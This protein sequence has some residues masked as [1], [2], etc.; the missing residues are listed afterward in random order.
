MLSRGRSF[1]TP[2]YLFACLVMGG[3]A[4][5]IWANM[6]LQL[7][8]LAIIA[9]AAMDRSD[10]RLAPA[11]WQLLALAAIALV[12]VAIQLVPLAPSL[13]THLGPRARIADGFRTL[14]LPI[15]PEP[16]SLSPAGTLNSLLGV[17]PPIAVFCA[18]VRLK[19]YRPHLL[20]IALIAGTLAGI[21]LGAL[22]VAS[23]NA[24]L[25]PWYLYDDT[26]VGRAVGFFANAD[27]MATLLVVTIPFL[28]ATIAAAKTANM[29]RYS[30]VVAVA[31]GVALVVLVGI[32]LNGSLA[33]YA[34]ALPVIAASALVTLPA[35]SKLRLPV[36]A[37]ALL[38]M[39]GAIVAME[40][41][42]IGS[43]QIGQ[44]AS[45]AVDSRS[46]L[47]ATTSR[48]A[49]DFMP[50]GSGL[51]SFP[52]VYSLYENPQQV[53]SIYVVHAHNDYVELALELGLAGV[54]L[55]AL[56]LVWWALG[57]WRAWR[58]AEAGPFARAA[59]IA[60]AAILF[61]S[62]V[63]FPLRTAAI[64]ACFGLCLALLADSRAAPPKEEKTALR[65][66]RHREF[67]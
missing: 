26:S 9:W 12:V 52:N 5:G 24:A 32:A 49:A 65:R 64:A 19:A 1:V 48:A 34:L 59:A 21:A 25:S 3:S 61:H 17:I 66:R 58:T 57:V 14:G 53:T 15:P 50:F 63:D 23:S 10:E 44:H 46:T 28:A 35:G 16:L 31:V 45:S 20:A 51:G 41:T 60:S 29:Q 62:A 43:R 30:A 22:Q 56:F 7:A 27:H 38:M 40:S 4:Q 55:I 8:G 13:W 36:I 6:I 37:I 11:A 54:I 2:A 39:I 42:A 47:L 18:M 67:K 33:G